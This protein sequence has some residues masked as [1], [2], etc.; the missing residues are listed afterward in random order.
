MKTTL[1]DELAIAANAYIGKDEIPALSERLG[2]AQST[3]VDIIRQRKKATPEQ[4]D[5]IQKA[6]VVKHKVYEK[7]LKSC[8]YL[9]KK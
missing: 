2:V 8:L 9:R 5:I 7:H 1:N 6:C 3:I 4:I